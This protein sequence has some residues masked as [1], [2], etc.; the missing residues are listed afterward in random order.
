MI[1]ALLLP[2]FLFGGFALL[3]VPR[4]Q[5]I[6]RRWAL[7]RRRSGASDPATLIANARRAQFLIK[8]DTGIGGSCLVR[9]LT[10]WA[11]LL[12]RGVAAELRVGMRRTDGRVEGHAW[13][14]YS[15]AP[16]NER[17][18]VVRTYSIYEKPLSFDYWHV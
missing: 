16:L 2:V 10:L 3:G 17:A 4:T 5:A 7:A 15:G 8:R 6:L 1:E 13:L 14:E 12:R 9:S 11:M 18:S